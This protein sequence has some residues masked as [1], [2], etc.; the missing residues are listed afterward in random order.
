M[1]KKWEDQNKLSIRVLVQNQ[2]QGK[3]EAVR[4]GM[5]EA[6]KLNPKKIGFLDA[7][8]S[9]TSEECFRLSKYINAT[10][11]FVF[12]SRIK[13]IDNTI[14]RKWYRFFIGRVIATIISKMLS[15]P[16]YDTQC[17]GKVFDASIVRMLFEKCFISR[18]LF[19]VELFFRAME[20]LGKEEFRQ[21]SMEVPV[22][23]WIDTPD[24]KVPFGYAFSLWF[25]L[26]KIYKKYR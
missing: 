24:S 23:Q 3:A 25:D 22:E 26:I 8:L 11:L 13:K 9:V 12:G 1:L 4:V 14:E 17:G 15:L 16:V 18:W 7:D 6:L 5:L 2:N 21:K 19:D 20:G 10:I